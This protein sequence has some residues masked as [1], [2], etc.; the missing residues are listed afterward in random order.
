MTVSPR[1]VGDLPILAYAIYMLLRYLESQTVI[2]R[3]QKVVLLRLFLAG[4]VAR[5]DVKVEWDK[6]ESLRPH[7]G[8]S[9]YRC[10]V[11]C[12]SCPLAVNGQPNFPS[13]SHP[14]FHPGRN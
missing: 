1:F 6:V 4:L 8:E 12:G 2:S 3:K 5:Y 10:A 11:P 14:R 9:G 7:F 13:C